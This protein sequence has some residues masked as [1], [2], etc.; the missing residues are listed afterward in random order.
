[1]VKNTKGGSGHK[2]YGRKYQTG[3]SSNFLRVAQEEGEIYAIVTKLLGNNMFHCHCID[4][5][6]R[7]GHIR[8][9]FTGRGKRDNM[10]AGGTWV[11]IGLRTWS[12]G[13]EKKKDD[14]KT[15]IEHCDL[16]EVYSDSEKE[17][18]RDTISSD[19]STLLTNDPTRQ[20]GSNKAG[21]DINDDGGD[22]RFATDQDIERDRLIQEMNSETAERVAVDDGY[23][24]VD[25][26]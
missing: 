22:F 21:Q 6:V 3:G 19:W 13:G 14:E 15:K 17:R 7:L 5:V 16:V 25:D 2:K 23:V 12:E 10:I 18:L 9:K 8:G 4:N 11:L 24:N 26:I 1:M 20:V